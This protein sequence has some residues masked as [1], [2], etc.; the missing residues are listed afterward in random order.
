MS[1]ELFCG[2]K[3]CTKVPLSR[4]PW[5]P[6]VA[7][8]PWV[9]MAMSLIARCLSSMF[10]AAALYVPWAHAADPQKYHVQFLSTGDGRRDSILKA[11]SQLESLRASGPVGPVGLLFRART[12]VSRL[13]TVLESFGYY[14]SSVAITFNDVR[15]EDP[16]LLDFLSA[17]PAGSDAE[18]KIT[19]TLGP[20]YHLGRIDLD[21]VP[22]EGFGAALGLTPGEPA[23]ADNVLAAVA[24][25]R[26]A[27][28]NQGFAFANVEEPVA[29]EVPERLV[30]DVRIHAVT[31]PKV[32][33]GEIRITG[34]RHVHESLLRRRLRL[35]EGDTYSNTRIEQ[36]RTD[37]LSLAVFVTVS[38]HVGAADSRGRVPI[39][40]HVQE[41]P[42]HAA[43]LRAAYSSD[44]GGSSGLTWSNR[45]VLGNA[46]RLDLSAS[47][48]NIGGNATEAV[49]YDFS[50]RYL[51]PD[52][53]RLDQSLQLTLGALKQ[54]LQA[55]DQTEQTAALTLRR[56]LS[57]VWSASAG[58]SAAYDFVVQEGERRDYTILALPLGLSY[59]STDLAAPLDDPL[60]G[61]RA[62]LTL[63]PTISL[64][65]PNATFLVIQAL[66]VSYLDLHPLLKTDPGR[67]VLVLRTLGGLAA[68]AGQFD[69]P[70]DQRFYAGGS[71]TIR[72]YRYQSVG[73]RFSDGTPIG[74]T[75][76]SAVSLEFRQRFGQ[77]IGAAVFADAG[78]VSQ[79]VNPFAGDGRLGVG[80]GLRYYTPIGPLR[81]DA[82]FPT[83][84][85]PDDDRFEI[86]VGLGQS[87]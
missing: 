85:G 64:G 3:G 65:H 44:L 45:N 57:S 35:H 69:L 38:V 86:Y 58:I 74:G 31:G 48:I 78:L 67:S 56:K 9:A 23:I 15:L 19:L 17:L 52:V 16:G 4:C 59:D 47:V 49:G 61:L 43:S 13:K 2:L 26:A 82:A 11:T 10:A 42:R 50:A 80:A 46:E 40:F 71:G 54:S 41:R 20:L 36:A 63:A 14:Q 33:L 62:S 1:H 66:A 79:S 8:A 32:Q 83:K 24:R 68:G 18:C 53:L 7:D 25:L 87:F 84:R 28:Q 60:H 5:V 51:M 55:Y 75:A 30:L 73:P 77:S 21:G 22:P 72:G 37:F 34:L 29:Y 81:V 70:P 6:R 76:L 12:D 39:T 27:L